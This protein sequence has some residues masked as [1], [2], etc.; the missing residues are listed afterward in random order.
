MQQHSG[1]H[2]LSGVIHRRYGFHNVGFHMGAAS[3]TIDFDGVIP[4]EDLPGWKPP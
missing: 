3:V 2:M 4:Q 1:E